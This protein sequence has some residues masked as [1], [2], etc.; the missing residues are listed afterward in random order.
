MVLCHPWPSAPLVVS[1]A[2]A[3]PGVL[4][5]TLHELGFSAS[6][7]P[8]RLFTGFLFGVY[9]AD[10]LCA[11]TQLHWSHLA[12]LISWFFLMQT[13]SALALWRGRRLEPLLRRYEEGMRIV[14]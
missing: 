13:G 11:L 9:G 14:P 12:V 8:R 6:S 4:D 5:F 3:V 7:T 2:I 10:V 1:L